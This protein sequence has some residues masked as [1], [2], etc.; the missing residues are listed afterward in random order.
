FWGIVFLLTGSYF[1]AKDLGIAPDLTESQWAIFL[2][3]ISVA[4]FILYF[5][6][7]LQDWGML[8]PAFVAGGLAIIISL[9]ETGY[10]GPGL[11]T[12]ILWAVAIPFWIA[13][14]THPNNNWWASIPG[15]ALT[16]IG[17]IILLEN[18]FSGDLIGSLIMVSI[19][20]PF[21]VVY[22]R[23][24]TRAWALIPGYALS[25][26]ALIVLFENALGDDATGTFV[27]FAV[28]LPFY[29]VYF[30][31]KSNRWAIIPAGVLSVVAL[32]ALIESLSKSKDIV[33][34]FVLVTFG[35]A[36]FLIYLKWREHWWAIIPAGVF[37]S[38]AAPVVLAQQSMPTVNKEQ[39][40]SSIFLAGLAITFGVL[41]M[42][43][44][45]HETAWAIYPSGI[46]A[47][48]AVLGLTIGVDVAWPITLIVFGIWMLFR[49]IKNT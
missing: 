25:V 26:I 13:L 41:W 23:N 38:A 47:A 15:W 36:F 31:N 16:V 6:N 12:I 18:Q 5:I 24:R 2:G 37:I 29:F 3:I 17:G 46:L 19:A 39:L 33:G 21:F 22:I 34:P 43:R 42:L 11:G 7:K 32:F 14:I 27:L 48:Y 20:L 9:A 4:F 8:F 45:R 30:Q 35:L 28:A 44:N 1:F 49:N 40:L 10:E